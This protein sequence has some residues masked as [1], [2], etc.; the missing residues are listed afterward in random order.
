MSNFVVCVT[1]DFTAF[2]YG[3]SYEVL[4]DFLFSSLIDLIDDN[5]SRPLPSRY[6]VIDNKRVPY[7]ITLD[8]W[9]N[10]KLKE[11]GI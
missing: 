9:R 3:K 2:T 11:I 4:S 5:G 6:G 10:K 1:K 7:F 8:E